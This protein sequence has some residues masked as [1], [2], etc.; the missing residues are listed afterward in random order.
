MNTY[1][2]TIPTAARSHAMF[3]ACR[4][5]SQALRDGRSMVEAE[6]ARDAAYRAALT[7]EG[8]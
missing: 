7:E 2:N 5:A 8:Q 1:R 4:A 6:A 3:V